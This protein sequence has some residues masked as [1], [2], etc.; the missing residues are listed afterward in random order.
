V[1]NLFNSFPL[2][3]RVLFSRH[4]IFAIQNGKNNSKGLRK[5]LTH[6]RYRTYLPNKNGQNS[7]VYVNL[8]MDKDA[9]IKVH[10]SFF[11]CALENASVKTIFSQPVAAQPLTQFISDMWFIVLRNYNILN[12]AGKGGDKIIIRG[13]SFVVQLI[14]LTVQLISRKTH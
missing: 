4:Q 10:V 6:A 13:C 11:S 12:S 1:S 8:I 14:T 3:I 7:W 9:M 5:I 2:K